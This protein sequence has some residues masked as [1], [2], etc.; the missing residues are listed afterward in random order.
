M[1][2]MT[3]R[4]AFTLGLILGIVSIPIY[5]IWVL[6][7]FDTAPLPLWQEVLYFPALLVIR[8]FP[9]SEIPLCI[10]IFLAMSV[11]YG[12]VAMGLWRGT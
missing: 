4:R 8:L 10:C 2:K 9:F 7:I 5:F 6:D 11:S 1:M 3:N 12:F